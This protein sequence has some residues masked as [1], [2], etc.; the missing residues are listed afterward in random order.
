VLDTE[1]KEIT[2]LTKKE[3]ADKHNLNYGSFRSHLA[4]GK[5]SLGFGRGKYDM[6][7][8]LFRTYRGILVRCYQKNYLQYHNYGGRG[9]KMCG[10]WFYSFDAFVEDMGPRPGP[11]YSIDRVDNDGWYGPDNC[12]WATRKEQS[13]NRRDKPCISGH[14]YIRYSGGRF[15]IWSIYPSINGACQY[16]GA[17]FCL[18]EAIKIRD[19][20]LKEKNG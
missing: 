7:H 5:C 15:K 8:P 1:F 20:F 3:Y 6:S 4:R 14:R 9:I 10:R 19:K 17:T 11:E 2:G 13:N 18:E 12:R 16:L